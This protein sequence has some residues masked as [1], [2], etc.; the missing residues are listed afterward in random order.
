MTK[1][2][3]NR[4]IIQKNNRLNYFYNFGICK[5]KNDM[6]TVF[7]RNTKNMFKN[8]VNLIIYQNSDYVLGANS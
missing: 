5:K 1:Y 2:P 6:K 3:L 7:A 4:Y 8:N